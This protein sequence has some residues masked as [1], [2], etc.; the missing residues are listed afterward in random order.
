MPGTAATSLRRAEQL[1]APLPP[2]LV[3]AQRIAAT[4]LPGLHGRRRAGPGNDFWQFRPYQWGD[5]PQQIDW[6]QSARS[7]RLY[8]REREWAAAQSVYLWCDASAS[9]RWHSMPDLPPKHERAELLALALASLLA[10]AGERF[11]DLTSG[12]APGTGRVALERLALI[13]RR[14]QAGDS[15]PAFRLLPHHAR[16]VLFGDFLSPLAEIEALLRR[17]AER[18]LGGHLIQILDPAEETFP[19]TG[20]VHFEGVE[21]EG[22]LLV[23]GLLVSRAEALG[24]AYAER[25]AAHRRGLADLARGLGWTFASTRTDR[26]A[27]AT[28]LALYL[29][30]QERATI[31]AS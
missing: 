21:D 17:F 4:V 2:L 22:G 20:R 23:S 18:G 13:L 12:V 25:L 1:A 16:L 27:A 26:P 28:L 19:F 31:G 3:A 8:L 11:A 6:R 29:R 10:R 9:M 14:R 30:L 24:P 15:L 5:A 7:E